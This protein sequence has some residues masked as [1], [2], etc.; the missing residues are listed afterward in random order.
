MFC[1]GLVTLVWCLAVIVPIPHLAANL[2]QMEAFGVGLVGGLTSLILGYNAAEHFDRKQQIEHDGSG[3]PYPSYP[4]SP[5]ADSAA[6]PHRFSHVPGH[7]ATGAGY[8]GAGAGSRVD[9]PYDDPR[10]AAIT[11]YYTDRERGQPG[12]SVGSA[13]HGSAGDAFGNADD[14]RTTLNQFGRQSGF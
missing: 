5:Y 7:T 13:Q 11:D 9:A 3:Y 2:G 14:F 8:A 6:P 4:G 10:D 12:G 1:I